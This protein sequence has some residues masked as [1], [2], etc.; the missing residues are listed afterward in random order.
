MVHAAVFKVDVIGEQS[1]LLA[2]G[3][4]LGYDRCI[5]E[6]VVSWWQ[7]FVTEKERHNKRWNGIFFFYAVRTSSK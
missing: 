4:L 2:K 1:F 3:G 5:S 7:H 6:H